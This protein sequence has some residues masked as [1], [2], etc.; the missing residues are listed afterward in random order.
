MNIKSVFLV[1]LLVITACTTDIELIAPGDLLPVV[2]CLL[3]PEDS[4]QYVRLGSTYVINPGDTMFKPAQEKILIDEEILVYLSAEYSD[5]QQEVF[6]AS[7]ID[8]IPKD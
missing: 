6:Y 4:I 5:R 1:L 2:Y 7:R 8:T 3:D